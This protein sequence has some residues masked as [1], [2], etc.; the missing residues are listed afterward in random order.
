MHTLRFWGGI[1]LIGIILHL[2]P[3]SASLADARTITDAA[4]RRVEI[5]QQVDRVICSGPG[6]LRLLTYLQCQSKIVAVDDMEKQR[7]QF[8][9]RPYALANPQFKQYPIFGEFRGHDHPERILTLD[10]MPQVIFK[11]YPTMG[12]DPV[13]LSRKT[14]IPVIVLDYGN[15]GNRRVDLY[16]SLR[17][18]GEVMGAAARAEQVIAFFEESIADLHRRTADIPENRRPSCFVGGIAYRGPHGFQSTEPTYPPFAFVNARNLAADTLGEEKALQQSSVAKEK[19]VAW[20][21]EVLFLDL[22]T[23]QMGENAG[24]LFELKTDPAYA[25]LTAVR[26]GRVYG[27]L[28]Y[29]WYT[30]NFGS[31]LADAY[32]IGRR[33]YP[34]RFADIEPAAKADEI[35]TFLVGRPVFAAINASFGRLAFTAVP[36]GV[37]EKTNQ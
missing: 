32:F 3:A 24:G 17:I 20:D 27:L 16:R 12:H 21:P 37:R 34:D 29:N 2:W 31:I 36:L 7:P 35:Y 4:G 23:L 30:Q 1:L 9:A 10:P 11:T 25:G 15:L 26:S 13:E 8:D 33:L 5:P 19:I 28:P 22:S 18:M 6:A 14:G